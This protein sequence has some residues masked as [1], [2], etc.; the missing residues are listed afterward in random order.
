MVPTGPPDQSENP[1]RAGGIRPLLSSEPLPCARIAS[2]DG[3]FSTM[4]F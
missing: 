2:V 1:E 3:H 4:K